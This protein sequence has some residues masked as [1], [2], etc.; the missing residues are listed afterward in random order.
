ME[1]EID[2]T[3]YL[4]VL[5]RRWK[6]I[7]IVILILVLVTE[8]RVITQ[9]KAYQARV[10]VATVRT[11]TEVSFNTAIKTVSEDE[12]NASL[13]RQKR[14]VSFVGLI[15]NPVIAE[16]VIVKLGDQLPSELR[17][18]TTLLRM[19]KGDTVKGS[20]LIAISANHRDP[21]V[22]ALVANAWGE[23]YVRQVN[24]TY[25]GTV[26]ESLGMVR[27]EVEVAKQAYDREQAALEGLLRQDRF[28]ELSRR[29]DESQ[30]AIANLVA[31]QQRRTPAILAERQRV[32]RLL[33]DVQAMQAQVRAGGDAAAASSEP[34]ILLLKAQVFADSSQDP[35]P[36]AAGAAITRPQHP[37]TLSPAP[38]VSAPDG[39]T[40]APSSSINSTV[41]QIQVSPAT[42]TA[43]AMVKDLE[44][45]GTVL[46][47]RRNR[48]DEDLTALASAMMQGVAGAA[49]TKPVA[50]TER[51]AGAADQVVDEAIQSLDAQSRDLRAELA[52]ED[53]RL[54]EAKAR[55]D[56]AWE[57]YDNLSRKQAEVAIAAQATG[58][59]VRLAA[60]AV[61]QGY[62]GLSMARE[63]TKAGAL[64]LVLGV[65]LAYLVEFWHNYRVRYRAA[66]AAR[67][68]S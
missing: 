16:Q 44:A 32:D 48:L 23:E 26:D 58:A 61:V 59:Q 21:K 25:G 36:N 45:L 68:A 43:E 46:T 6:I 53:S 42:A 40:N 7:L 9:P 47:E 12:L 38:L 2:L 24:L 28:D 35:S 51:P 50:S 34:A 19:V 62:G 33:R 3:K 29:L 13:D 39:A 4:D 57:T 63:A 41:V 5:I 37:L 11:M 10:L 17:H 20:D 67:K 60:P 30:A 18:A 14:L 64:G 22:A 52:Q 8:G 1:Q 56:L 66:R 27:A 54:R 15:E 65:V 31:T 49:S 55:R